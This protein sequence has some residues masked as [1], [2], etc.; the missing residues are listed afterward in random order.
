VDKFDKKH[1]GSCVSYFHFCQES[2]SRF[3]FLCVKIVMK[4]YRNTWKIS[5]PKG[6]RAESRYG[7][8]IADYYGMQFLHRDGGKAYDFILRGKR[9]S[10]IECKLEDS[11]RYNVFL[12]TSYR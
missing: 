6:K 8:L 2:F 4:D 5:Y 12:E 1:R 7:K 3:Q 11:A 10:K 9:D